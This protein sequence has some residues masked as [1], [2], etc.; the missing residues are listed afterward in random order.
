MKD[1]INKLQKTLAEFSPD[2]RYQEFSSHQT[3]LQ[4]NNN[5]KVYRRFNLYLNINHNSLLLIIKKIIKK[6]NKII[7]KMVN[8]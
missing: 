2:F 4:D 8:N 3:S 7:I 1:I 6:A 5:I